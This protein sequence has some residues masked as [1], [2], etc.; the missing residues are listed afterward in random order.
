MKTSHCNFCPAISASGSE[1]EAHLHS[2]ANCERYYLRNYKTKRVLPILIKVF[3]CL[4]CDVPGNIRIT[5]HL[6]KSERCKTL[7]FEKFQ[8]DNMEVLQK[9]LNLLRKQTMP[10]KVNRKLELEKAKSKRENELQRKT[11]ADM[12]N[13]YRKETCFAN[14]LQCYKCKSNYNPGSR[15]IEEVKLSEENF[16]DFQTPEMLLKRRFRKF[17]VCQFC[18]EKKRNL[19]LKEPV[20]GLKSR[21]Y[22]G[23]IVFAPFTSDDVLSQMEIG[24]SSVT[25]I[26]PCT[27]DCVNYLGG[28]AFN[29]REN[30]VGAMYQTDVNLDLL[31]SVIYENEVHKYKQLKYTADRYE[32]VIRDQNP[33]L[34]E[35]AEKVVNDASVTGSEAWRRIQYLNLH[36]RVQQIGCLSL[37]LCLS[38]PIDSED[39]LST[40]LLQEGKVVTVEI[41]GDSSNEHET[42]YYVHDHNTDSNCS[43]NCPKRL[44]K[45]YLDDTPVEIGLLKT[46][47][48]ATYLTSVQNKINALISNFIKS[49][50]SNLFSEEYSLQLFFKFDG[51]IDIR[52]L[53]WLKSMEDVNVQFAKYPT[54]P[55]EKN[56]IIDCINNLDSVLS[57]TSDEKILRKKFNISEVQSKKLS[58]LVNLHQFHYC[59][60]DKRCQNCRKPKLPVLRTLLLEFSSSNLQ[61]SFKLNDKML[62]KLVSLED[63]EVLSMRTE[64]WLL[65]VFNCNEVKISEHSEDSFAF[66]MDS[67]EFLFKMDERLE[68][69]IQLFHDEYPDLTNNSVLACYHYAASTSSMLFAGGA[70]M[71]RVNIRDSYIVDYNVALLKAFQSK[72]EIV[73][74][75]GHSGILDKLKTQSVMNETEDMITGVSETHQEVPVTEA[76]CLFDKKFVRSFTSNPVEFV[77][78][79]EVRK[80]FF[81][82][83]KTE[84]D[85]SYKVKDS[86]KLFVQLLTGIE[87]FFLLEND[88]LNLCS[89]EFILNYNF[90]GEEESKNLLKLFSKVA[91]KD[92]DKTTVF[93]KNCFLPE[94]LVLKNND[95]MQLRSK[96]KVLTFPS[97]EKETFQHMYRQVLLFSP[98]AK[99]E[100]SKEEVVSLFN[101]VDEEPFK[102]EKGYTLTIIERMER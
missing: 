4:F 55:L 100:M 9:K 45:D 24:D 81:K 16:E 22:E 48:L 8:T 13:S 80:K 89:A 78:A 56:S 11:E 17:F 2:S 92:S 29:S 18:I 61:M 77:P 32:G 51:T 63:E 75:N 79:F 59:G 30:D 82:Q 49:P 52:G 19:V 5:S 31:L 34:L 99:E 83:V 10:S 72:I 70:I 64:E 33:G 26:L 36:P 25:C 96:V 6:Q 44:M 62:Q 85:K 1:L 74:V 102:D 3:N 94:V 69:F 15:R 57:A 87:R 41:S 7:Y 12:L 21:K 98:E 43:E 73:A 88:S 86:M 42:K 39:V 95:V 47:Y 90:S 66:N 35:S 23:N 54:V 27:M 20:I 65:K 46:K 84:S 60:K 50:S 101:K 68:V 67:E 91:I 76:F 71:E 40:I 28:R 58:D 14:F 38:I 53:I 93:S 97:F 37:F